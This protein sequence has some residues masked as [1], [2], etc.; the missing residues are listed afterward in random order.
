MGL[1]TLIFITAF[2]ILYLSNALEKKPELVTKAAEQIKA[3]I[4]QLALWGAAYGAIAL[5]LTLL[6]NANGG[7]M[8]IRFLAN[9]MVIVMALPFI[10]DKIAA[11]FQAKANP[12]ILEEVKHAVGWVTRQE[13]YIGYVGAALSLLL[14]A[15]VFR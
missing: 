2:T 14:F 12:A 4:D 11:K 9:I 8:L 3:H 15:V 13:K 1:I 5:V 6:M 10:F 7:D